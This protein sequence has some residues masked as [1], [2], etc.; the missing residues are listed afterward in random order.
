MSF[1]VLS[2]GGGHYI[3]RGKKYVIHLRRMKKINIKRLVFEFLTTKFTGVSLKRAV[4]VRYDET[5]ETFVSSNGVRVM[6]FRQFHNGKQFRC[7]VNRFVMKDLRDYF[8]LHDMV[9]EMYVMEWCRNNSINYPIFVQ[10][11]TINE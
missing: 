11:Y 7:R 5:L 4:T 3:W 8:D 1:D 10:D 9:I 2:L 6:E